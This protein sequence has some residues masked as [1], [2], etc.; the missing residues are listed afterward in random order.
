M[1]YLGKGALNAIEK[2]RRDIYNR[3]GSEHL[4]ACIRTSQQPPNNLR[5]KEWKLIILEVNLADKIT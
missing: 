1:K 4:A 3:Q 2:I 5:G